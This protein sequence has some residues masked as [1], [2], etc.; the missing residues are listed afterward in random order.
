[1]NDFLA[2]A[3]SGTVNLSR[4]VVKEENP[5]TEP[6]VFPT[7]GLVCRGLDNGSPPPALL[8]LATALMRLDLEMQMATAKCE[9]CDGES[10]E[11]RQFPD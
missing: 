6:K 1:M 3:V 10:L 2:T 11:T 7:A 9:R 8:A 4:R 5:G